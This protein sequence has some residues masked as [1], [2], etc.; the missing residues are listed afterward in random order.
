MRHSCK[1]LGGLFLHAVPIL[2]GISSLRSP[3]THPAPPLC[4]TCPQYGNGQTPAG[5]DIPGGLRPDASCTIAMHLGQ[6][7]CTLLFTPSEKTQWSISSRDIWTQV[8]AGML[9]AKVCRC[10]H[11]RSATCK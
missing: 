6:R 5:E 9:C 11:M 3:H 7:A 8:R 1:A 10:L 4:A 2:P